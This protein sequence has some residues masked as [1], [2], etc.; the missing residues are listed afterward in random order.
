[1]RVLP[2]A[3]D[4]SSRDPVSAFALR[5]LRGWRGLAPGTSLADVGAVLAVDP[6]F[7]GAAPLGSRYERAD[8]VAATGDGF[9][10]GVR[11]WLRGDRVVLLDAQ[12]ME[13][14]GQDALLAEL[15]EPEARWDASLGPMPVAGSEWVYP[16]RGLTLFLDPGGPRV[17]RVLGYAPTTLDAYAAALRP[18]TR[19]VPLPE[20]GEVW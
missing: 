17:D 1:V 7:D 2:L 8:W 9:P 20:G 15:G 12:R 16:A 18:H 3:P 5:D 6:D 13:L 4:R 11:V 14:P 10:D 19:T